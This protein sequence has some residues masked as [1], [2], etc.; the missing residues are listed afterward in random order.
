MDRNVIPV[1]N[2]II[3]INS[4]SITP[5]D[6]FILSRIDGK[7][8][9]EELCI[10]SGVGYKETRESISRLKEEGAIIFKDSDKNIDLTDKERERIDMFYKLME[11]SNYYEILGV[12]KSTDKKDIKRRYFELSKEFHPDKFFRRSLGDYKKR[13]ERIFNRIKEAYYILSDEALRE[14]YDNSI[15]EYNTSVRNAD[16]RGT[17]RAKSLKGFIEERVSKGK[18]YYEIAIKEFN[19]GNIKGAKNNIRLAIS[20]DS[21]NKDYKDFLSKIEISENRK[22]AKKF[23]E[24]GVF[25]EN[26]GEYKEGIEYLE[27]AI[28][29]DSN[30]SIY[31]HTL[32]RWLLIYSKDYHKAK[33]YCLKAI[34]IDPN[35][36]EY[37]TTL[38]MIYKSVKLFKNAIREFKRAL[39]LDKN[40]FIAKEGLEEVKKEV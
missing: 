3:D 24:L 40:S 17:D 25:N 34:D 8:S 31:F 10:I 26:I 5:K 7:I 38:G 23:Y 16:Y 14:E 36:S 20:F 39:E 9:V 12:N 28:S 30:N 35:N 6:A 15:K 33:D 18:R 19:K 11:D 27:K 22:E 29:L 1:V 21:W 13:L 4:L 37:H 2:P 32:S